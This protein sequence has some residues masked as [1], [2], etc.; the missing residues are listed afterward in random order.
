M[1]SPVERLTSIS[2][3]SRICSALTGHSKIGKP[4]LI[5]FLKNMRAKDFAMTHESPAFYGIG[6]CSREE[7]HPKLSPATITSPIPAFFINPDRHL[8]MQ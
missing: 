8:S 4:I 5:A 1:I 7:P 3:P 6:A 2:S